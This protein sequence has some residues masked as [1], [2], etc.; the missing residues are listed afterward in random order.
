MAVVVLEIFFSLDGFHNNLTN[1]V[2]IRLKSN[3][4][5]SSSDMT[6]EAARLRPVASSLEAFWE[7]QLNKATTWTA[8]GLG[9]VSTFQSCSYTLKTGHIV[10]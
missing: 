5:F 10:I 3:D 7:K 2:S 6:L 9:R 1:T 8:N 4:Q